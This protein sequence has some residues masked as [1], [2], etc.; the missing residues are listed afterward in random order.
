MHV[1]TMRNLHKG[2]LKK[3]INFSKVCISAD[4]YHQCR[5]HGGHRQGIRNP[6]QNIES[7]FKDE[8]LKVK[9]DFY[10]YNN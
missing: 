10:E 9:E 4:D 7:G 3:M 2:F 6:S 5:R 8:A 1:N